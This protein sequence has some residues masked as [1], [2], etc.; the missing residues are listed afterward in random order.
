MPWHRNA[1]AT[2]LPPFISATK[3]VG[4]EPEPIRGYDSTRSAPR[5]TIAHA[6]HPTACKL[7]KWSGCAA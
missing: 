5:R 1:S 7:P 6:S 2:N 3:R 4:H